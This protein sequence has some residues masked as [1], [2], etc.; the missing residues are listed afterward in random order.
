VIV[1]GSWNRS[2]KE[3]AGFRK[4]PRI[5]LNLQA[6]RPHMSEDPELNRIQRRR[7]RYAERKLREA[8]LRLAR[9]ERSILYWSRILADLRY[10]R[11]RAVQSPLWPE[12]ETKNEN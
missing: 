1:R 3:G 5:M 4:I 10:E 2:G 11:T 8:Q 12:E 6:L 7:M 9:T